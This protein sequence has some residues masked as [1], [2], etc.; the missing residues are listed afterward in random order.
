MKRLA[1]TRAI[2]LTALLLSLLF[3]LIEAPDGAAQ[4]QHAER[5]AASSTER[6]STAAT[7]NLALTSQLQRASSGGDGPTNED[8]VIAPQG[9]Q[10]AT[11]AAGEGGHRNTAAAPSRELLHPRM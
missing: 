4:Y 11:E 2:H 3:A 10:D 7:Q 5:D 6:L 9:I 8:G 1:E